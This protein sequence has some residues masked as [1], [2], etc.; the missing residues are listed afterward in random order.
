LKQTGDPAK[1]I[2]KEPLRDGT[3]WQLTQ[4]EQFP[5]GTVVLYFDVVVRVSYGQHR[6]I[7]RYDAAISLHSSAQSKTTIIAAFKLF[8]YSSRHTFTAVSEQ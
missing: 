6:S 5:K 3:P 4:V 2:S 7:R 1:D 8:R